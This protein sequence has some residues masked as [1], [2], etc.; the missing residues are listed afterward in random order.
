MS[1]SVIENSAGAMANALLLTGNAL[2]CTVY[3][4]TFTILPLYLASC[5][6]L[7]TFQ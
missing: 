2:A 3:I 6:Q 7:I 4:D 5:T 1:T